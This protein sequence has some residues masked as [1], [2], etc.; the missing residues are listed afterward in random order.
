[1]KD[2]ARVPALSPDLIDRLR[3]IVGPNHALTDPDQ[4]LPYLREWRDMYEGRASMVLRP[5]STEEVSRILALANEH[6]IP[7]VPQAGNTGLVGGQMPMRGEILLSVGRL[8]KVRAV[9]AQGFTMTVETGLTLAEAQAA[10]DNVNRLFPLSLPSEG[11]CQIGG[12]LGTNAGGVGVLAYGN[13][14][15]LVLGLE[16]VLA[17][18]R[19]WTGLNALKKDNTGYDLKDLF[20]GSEGTLGII[21][22]AV[23]KLFPKPAEKATA[24]LALPELANA[25]TL[26]GAAQEAASSSLTAFEFLPR[27]VLEM[28]LRNVPGTRDP[29]SEAHPWYVLM[30]ISGAKTDG[31]ADRVLSEILEAAS[32]KGLIT[33][34]RLA[35]SLGQARDFWRLREGVSEAQKPEGG[36][37]KNDVSVPIAKI[38]EFIARAN[39]AV[40]RVCPGARPLPLGHFGDGNVH[41]NIAQPI[42]MPKP[43]FMAL[44]SDLV[45]AVHE[46]VLH[47]DGSISAEHGIGQ[48]K[49]A[50]LAKAKGE[51]AMDL[52]RSIKA[53]LDPKGIL[54]PGKVL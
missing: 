38:P 17:D 45:G 10:A 36:N 29:F 54:N 32:E 47:Y 52:M 44:W 3:A 1:M 15:Q 40:L 31:T 19:I 49:R 5:G 22:A 20:I 21:T 37:I 13:M 8:K 50:E 11:T 24:I 53:A 2:T 6:G 26:F 39:A 28:V 9:D 46:T 7:V 35:A 4:Q 48:M 27:T 18:G 41:Y 51:V 33:D 25:I 42:G 12:N 14:R 30:E 23:L 16:V 34:A 43:Q